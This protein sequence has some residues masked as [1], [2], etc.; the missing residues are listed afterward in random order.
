MD[1]LLQF[2]LLPVVAVFALPHALWVLL[3]GSLIYWPV[4]GGRSRSNTA[5]LIV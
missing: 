2:A 4:L 5:L 3:A 1:W